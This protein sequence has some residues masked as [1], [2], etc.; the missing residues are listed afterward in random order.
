MIRNMVG[1]QEAYVD[2]FIATRA[3]E[4]GEGVCEFELDSDIFAFI[5][6]LGLP[7][8]FTVEVVKETK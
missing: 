8:R 1:V 3:D 2:I 7:V 6:K 4:D 5:G